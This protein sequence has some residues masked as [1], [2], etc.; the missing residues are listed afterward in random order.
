VQPSDAI[1]LVERVL[2]DLIRELLGDKWQDHKSI[3]MA[4][5]E[6]ARST[7]ATRRRG[8]LLPN[9]LLEYAD[10]MLLGVI[11]ENHWE[12]FKPVLGSIKHFKVYID[13]LG[14]FRN[15]V[16]HT[17]SLLPFERYCQDLWMRL[18][19]ATSDPVVCGSAFDVS[20]VMSTGVQAAFLCGTSRRHA[21]WR[22][23]LPSADPEA[24]LR[25]IALSH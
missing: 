15:P 11:I 13:R 12:D 3:D 4:R 19:Q 24:S 14:T 23:R 1:H 2:R 8:V 17:R 9:D 22:S 21:C 20:G 25:Q 10:F 6:E 7:E 5:L 18:F 16:M